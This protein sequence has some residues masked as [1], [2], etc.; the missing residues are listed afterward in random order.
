M[1]VYT[2]LTRR[3]LVLAS[4][5]P[6]RRDLLAAARLECRV[7]PADIPEVLGDGESPEAYV[8][9]LAW[10]KAHAVAAGEGEV[11]LAADTTVVV[12]EHV[13][14]KP[15]DAGDAARMLRLLSG[16]GHEVLTGICL[17]EGSSA[18]TAVERTGVR[19]A[20]LSERDI[21]EYVASGEPFGKAGA[22][23]IQGM[24][25]RWVVGVEGCYFNVVGLPVGL[26]WRELELHAAAVLE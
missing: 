3:R 10:E 7:A 6:R 19:V 25:S 11:V 23:G 4:A 21:E 20:R 1:D 13:L 9:R 15:V 24:F 2:Y 8:R 5:S 18:R 14:E 12:D 17:R 16:R 22:Y 26:V